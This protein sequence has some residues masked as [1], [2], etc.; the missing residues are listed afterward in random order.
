MNEALEQLLAYWIETDALRI[1]YQGASSAISIFA[2]PRYQAEKPYLAYA[3][4][5][6]PLTTEQFAQLVTRLASNLRDAGMLL[7]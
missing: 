2:R 6:V 4:F 3:L 7:D 1:E 5:K